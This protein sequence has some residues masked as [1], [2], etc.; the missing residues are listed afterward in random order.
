VVGERTRFYCSKECLWLDESNPGRYTG[1]RNFFDRYHGWEA[2]EVIRD[3]GFVRADGETLMGQPHLES[4][5]RWTLSDIRAHDV[6]LMSPNIRVAAELG[7][8]SG[9]WSS[10]PASHGNG[11]VPLGVAESDLLTGMS[12]R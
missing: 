3:L 7:L 9:D 1:D 2:S 4:V 5:G 8:P 12:L 10:A 6:K 11:A